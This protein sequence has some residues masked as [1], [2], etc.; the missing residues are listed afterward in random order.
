MRDLNECIGEVLAQD[1]EIDT[2]YFNGQVEALSKAMSLVWFGSIPEDWDAASEA[3]LNRIGSEYMRHGSFQLPE[4][5]M[6]EL[7]RLTARV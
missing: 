1:P 5:T 2:R 3:Y 4:H 6:V 7:L